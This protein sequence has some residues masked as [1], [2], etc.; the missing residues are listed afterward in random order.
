MVSPVPT[1]DPL[2]SVREALFAGNK[3]EAIKRYRTDVAKSAGLAEAKEFVEKLAAELYTQHPEK[4]TK[5][6]AKAGA[7]CSALLAAL[8]AIPILV[9]YFL[10]R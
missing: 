6:P 1:P 3:I 7:G 5:R 10:R 2:Q 4:F 9:W 8:A